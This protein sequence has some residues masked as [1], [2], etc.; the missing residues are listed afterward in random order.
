MHL[1]VVPHTHWDRQWYQPFQQ[2]RSRLVRLMDR[3]L[4]TLE[5]T[6]AFS[7]FHLDGQTIVLE[8][9][10]EIRPRNRARLRRLICAGRIAVGPWYVPPDEFLAGG[11]SLIR[12]LQLGHRVAAQFGTPL[13]VGYLPDQF[14][15]TAQMPQILAGFGIDCAVGWRG[16]GTDI[17]R[18]LFTWEVLDGTGVFTVYLP[19]SGYSNGRSLPEEAG[20][21]RERLAAIIA[22]QAPYRAVPS[23]LVMSGTDHQEAQATLPDVL[24]AALQGTESVTAEIA[25]LPRFTARARREHGELP[26]HRGELRS[27][28]RAHLLPGVT[29]SR[30]RQKQ[31]DFENVSRLERYAEP[32]ATWADSMGDTADGRLSDFIDWAWK[33]AL[34][35]HPH[36]SIA[37]CSVDQVH[38]DMEYRFDQVEVVNE[39]V[40]RRAWEGRTYHQRR[41]EMHPQAVIGGGVVNLG[42]EIDAFDTA[43]ELDARG[44]R[45][46]H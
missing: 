22:E 7:H 40:T 3:L 24:S 34:Q 38:R 36:D 6:P 42:F 4:E 28:L 43:V 15:H 16:V 21:M 25:P 9:Y 23:L 31:R 39:Q 35:N 29:S 44:D 26:A 17:T 14:G 30:V 13:K 8:D 32:L 33:V 11:E 46:R 41:P 1:V 5:S 2:F 12:N 27:P 45:H 20:E 18:T 19:Q 37:G 10:L